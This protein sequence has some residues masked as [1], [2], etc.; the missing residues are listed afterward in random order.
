M[1]T[2]LVQGLGRISARGNGKLVI[3]PEFEITEPV[4]GE[5]IAVNGCCLTLENYRAGDL[6]FHTLE[7]SLRR[8]NLG[9]L[10]IGSPVNLERA[11]RV[12][13][14]LGGH[15]VQGHVDTAAR[16]LECA[17]TADGDFKFSV[18][19]DPQFAKLVVVKGSIAIDGVSLTVVEAA[20]KMFAVRLIPVTLKDTALADRRPGMM[21]NL[22][23]D[24]VG[25]YILRM[26][27]VQER[28]QSSSGG[29]TMQTLLEAGFL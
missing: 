13:D 14:R 24:V 7:E 12:G 21:V 26:M 11:L 22:E 10:P 2:G 20:D 25:R 3:R 4:Y 15:I 18:E 17:R 29:V 5:S 16:V 1:F 27:E 19:L 23:F 28:E 6:T 8:T 9:S